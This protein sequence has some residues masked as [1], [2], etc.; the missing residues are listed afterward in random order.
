MEFI[1][2]SPSSTIKIQKEGGTTA[3]KGG[4]R[5]GEWHGPSMPEWPKMKGI[6][7]RIPPFIIRLITQ[8]T[9]RAYH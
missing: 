4:I 8:A 3:G 7:L 1:N 5:A 9:I 6:L 2:Q